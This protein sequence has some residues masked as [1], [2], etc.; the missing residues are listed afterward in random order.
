MNESF[1][2]DL[3]VGGQRAEVRK[4]LF[5]LF[6][7]PPLTSRNEKGFL[8]LEHLIAIAIMSILSIAFL[9]LMQIVSVY[10]VD[11][12]SLTMHEVNSLAIRL[13]NEVQ[14]A[15]SLTGT[16]GRLVAHFTREGDVVSF[17]AQNNR[18]VRQVNGRGGEIMVYHLSGMNVTLFDSRS[19]R[20]SLRSFDGDVFR[21]Y[22][23][24][25][26]VE[27]NLPEIW[28]EDINEEE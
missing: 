18:L 8:L 6:A 14:H 11:Q 26:H 4:N 15:D 13:Q 25:L 19:A 27:V 23:Q 17:T 2:Y 12:T 5:P 16:G 21:F 9:I 10:T 7:L 22:L 1:V 24:L 28:E 3:E 20:V